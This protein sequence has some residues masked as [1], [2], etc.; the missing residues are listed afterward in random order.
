MS[1]RRR[2]RSGR[3]SRRS[4]SRAI[5]RVRRNPGEELALFNPELTRYRARRYA[6]RAYQGGR[7]GL[8]GIAGSVKNSIPMLVGALAT[9]LVQRKWGDK[10]A[11]SANWTWKDYLM[12]LVGGLAASLL[13]KHALRLS[14]HTSQRILEGSLLLVGYKIVTN[15]LAP[16]SPTVSEWIGQDVEG[17]D[18]EMYIR[19]LDAI[20]SDEGSWSGSEP[21]VVGQ[22]VEGEDWEGAEPGDISEDEAGRPY[23]LGKDGNFRPVDDSHR[24]VIGGFGEVLQ[25]PSRLGEV[26][27]APTRLG[28]AP[29]TD[30]L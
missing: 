21:Y 9:K 30:F 5:V 22:D 3:S 7:G 13:A 16:M 24:A 2:G 25:T 17:S 14:P 15:E 27:Q 23:V 11:E 12:G 8:A 10:T 19:G 28:A 4:T 29:S 26:V 20:P 6:R 18:A 1:R